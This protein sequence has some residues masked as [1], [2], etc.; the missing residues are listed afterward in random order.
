MKKKIDDEFRQIR[1]AMQ[2]IKSTIF[3]LSTAVVITAS[4]SVILG[5]LHWIG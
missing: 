5:I 3:I 1:V 4:I 2:K